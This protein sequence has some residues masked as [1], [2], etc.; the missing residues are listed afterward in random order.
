MKNKR[1]FTLITVLI[2]ILA[3]GII[4]CSPGGGILVLNNIP[5]RYEG[6]YVALEA[7]GYISNNYVWLLGGQS[8][9]QSM[10]TATGVLIS[11]GTARIPMWIVTDDYTLERF[12]QNL[13]DAEMEII[14][15]TTTTMEED[16]AFL[17]FE[18]IV[19]VNGNATV[20]WGDSIYRYEY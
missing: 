2:L 10:D 4:G 15:F 14:I 3:M 17:Y 20:S 13:T 8:T 5:S 6:M 9:D 11:N 12:S 18:E 1:Q 16:L 19:F 7:A